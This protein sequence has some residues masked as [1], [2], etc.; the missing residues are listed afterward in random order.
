MQISVLGGGPGGLFFSI[1][2]KKAWPE[3]RIRVYERNKA[4]D[5]F[6][7]GVVF[8]DETLSEF[9]SRDPGSYDRI[10]KNFA[11]W[12]ELDVARDGEVVRISGNGFCGCSRKTLLHLLQER[13]REEG[14]ELNYNCSI[15]NPDQLEPADVVVLCDGIASGF[16]SRM[17]AEFGTRVEMQQNRFVWLGST[18]PLDAFTYFFRSTPWGTFVAH[19]YQYEEG[20]STWVIE[21][22]NEAWQ[23]AGFQTE[24]EA[25]T[26]A[27]LQEIFKEEL[28]G[29][30]FISNKSH[31]RQ[32]PL[33]TNARWHSGKYVLLG[34]AKASAHYSIG[35]GT[36]LAMEC[37]IGL[38]DAIL[39]NRTDREAAFQ[40][41]TQRRQGPVSRIQ[42]AANVSMAWFEAMDRHMKLPFLPF[43][44]S[45]MTRSKKVTLENLA[46]R[47][48]VFARSVVAD[49]LKRQSNSDS[50]NSP[51]FTP[52]SL[53][54]MVLPNRIVMSPMG[55]YQ[56]KEGVPGDWHL[57]HYGA[58]ATGGTGL[59]IAEMTAVA[60]EGRITEGCPG[61]W[62]D[63]QTAAWKRITDFVHGHSSTK[64]AIQLGH[65]GRK[66]GIHLPWE[67][68]NK[69]L[70][71]AWPRI[72]ASA[73]PY[74]ED[75][76]P[77]AE[78]TEADM[79]RVLQQFTAAAIRAE[80]AG[81][82]GIELQVHHGF[83]LAGF[84]SPLTNHRS[85]AY[86]GSV[87]NRLR[88]PLRVF[89]GIRAVFPPDKPVWVRLSATDWAPEGLSE[90]DFL[91]IAAAF[92]D[93]GAAVLHI[94][95]GGTVPHQKPATGRMW[96][97]PFSEMARN[98]LDIPVIAVG[99][100]QDIDQIN[101]LLLNGRADLV[102]LGKPLLLQPDF[103]LQAAAWEGL[104]EPPL[105]PGYQQGWPPLL[106]QVS[107]NRKS[108]ENMKKALKPSSHKPL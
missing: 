48:P 90:A 70:P 63:E 37:A 67:A 75:F 51:A 68:R 32:F 107:Q 69:P 44:F 18:R 41:Y 43:A 50:G 40:A 76:P 24:N 61:L 14:V 5:A 74:A 52:F 29:H 31:W 45:V 25:D 104:P 57:V 78:M 100:I 11:Y 1:L 56:A 82:D 64:M 20:N 10:R 58:R 81:F 65:S 98:T 36:K 3:A 62:N 9:L 84:L 12:D 47:D 35:S 23:K 55:Q 13:C 53:G 27:K 34:D 106:A 99:Q 59:I 19:T 80:S 77:P 87:E 42:H 54:K 30:H 26:L 91:T 60:P 4:D 33:V 105:P 79:D 46:L 66:G 38:A 21:T 17:S 39:Q 83:L 7:F 96:Q 16:R 102:A 73:I 108:I 103:A 95:S 8:S 85:D 88:F 89:Q 101:T 6:G 92:R 71:Y 22:S 15:D 97:T 94:S 86:G 28:Q 72:S 93:A 49:F 2:V